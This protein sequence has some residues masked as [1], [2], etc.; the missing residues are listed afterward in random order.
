MHRI[1]IAGMVIEI[2]LLHATLDPRARNFSELANM[3]CCS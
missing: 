2:A 1:R 3:Y